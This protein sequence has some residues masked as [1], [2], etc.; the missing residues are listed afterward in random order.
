MDEVLC[1][2]GARKRR[3]AS[4]ES[5]RGQTEA[6]NT[7][8]IYMRDS[9]TLRVCVCICHHWSR[10]FHTAHMYSC[11]VCVVATFHLLLVGAHNNSNP[12]SIDFVINAHLITTGANYQLTVFLLIIDSQ[13][14]NWPLVIF[15]IF[16]I[17]S[18]CI[19]TL[20]LVVLSTSTEIIVTIV[21]N[22]FS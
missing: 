22:L 19:L 10:V 17:L 21:L 18:Q 1:W 14:S 12:C 6:W 8:P 16:L 3:A 15:F 9:Y 20:V 4:S 11:L 13:F 2:G 7:T 5:P